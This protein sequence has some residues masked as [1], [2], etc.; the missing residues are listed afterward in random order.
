MF[1]DTDVTRLSDVE[2]TV[3]AAEEFGGP[4]SGGGVRRSDHVTSKNQSVSYTY[5]TRRP[6][7]RRPFH[8]GYHTVRRGRTKREEEAVLKKRKIALWAVRSP[9]VRRLAVRGLRSPR[10][11]RLLWAGVKRGVRRR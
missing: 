4:A 3:G 5:D 6:R 7:R 1:V 2:A 10:V 8:L 9:R 11:R